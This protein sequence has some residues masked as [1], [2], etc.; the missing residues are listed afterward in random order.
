MKN[1]SCI[2]LTGIVLGLS[3]CGDALGDW[4]SSIGCGD[5]I[6]TQVTRVYGEMNSVRTGVELCLYEGRDT[7]GQGAE[8][9]SFVEIGCS[10]LIS[11][12]MGKQDGF[13]VCPANTGTPQISSAPRLTKTSAITATFGNKAASALHG[14]TLTMTRSEDGFWVCSS[15]LL[16]E[17]AEY[18]PRGC[19]K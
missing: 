5:N 16:A 10:T 4:I 13:A 3:G 7:L 15:A 17:Y 19:E 1:L 18:A 14:K 6:R 12:T 2:F 9:C 11:D 8:Q